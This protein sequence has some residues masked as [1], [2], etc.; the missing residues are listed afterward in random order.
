ML[1]PMVA[2]A[3]AC[4]TIGLLPALVAPFLEAA[5]ATFGVHARLRSVAPI[6][7]VTRAG[8]LLLALLSAV[9]GALAARARRAA[10]APT[11]DCGYARPTARMQVTSS[12]F[13]DALVG[14]F[15]LA[16]RPQV[17]VERPAG[18]FPAKAS[19]HGA[20]PDLV[21][22]LWLLPALGAA[23]ALFASLRGLQQG[24][25]QAYLGYILFTLVLLLVWT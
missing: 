3:A 24:N 22:D 4:A 13:A 10:R 25:V 8:L 6:G 12:S 7:A 15:S 23:D 14:L 2:L 19:F 9:G 17:H 5:A 11:W 1:A 20:V 18:T 21:L 16:L